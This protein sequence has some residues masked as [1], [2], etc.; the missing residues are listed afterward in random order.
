MIN[1]FTLML[2]QITHSMN[3]KFI[4][5]YYLL[6]FSFLTSF[7][8]ENLIVKDTSKYNQE[9][10]PSEFDNELFSKMLFDKINEHR[11]KFEFDSI[12]DEE[13]LTQAAQD[14]GKYMASNNKEIIEQSGKKKT[15]GDRIMFYGGSKF[16]YELT[17]KVTIKKGKIYLT[18][19]QAIDEIIFKWTNSKK[20][21][22]ILDDKNLIFVGI[23]AYVD[24]TEKRLYVSA[25]FGNYKSFNKGA[26][27]RKELAVPYTKRKYGLKHFDFTVCKKCNKYK[28]IGELQ[29]N[30][31]VRDG[32]IWFKTDNVKKFK[33][34][35]KGGKDGI[36]VDIVQRAQYSCDD[37]NIIDN[38]L[39]NKGI[40]L[41]R[42][43]KNKLFRKNVYK[44]PKIRRQKLEVAIGKWPKKLTGNKNEYELNLVIIKEKHVCYNI[45]QS[46]TDN[47][48][49]EFNQSGGL[50]A[51][52]V[53]VEGFDE[54]IPKPEIT[55]LNF[56][57]PFEKN[58]STYKQEDI[59]PFVDALNEPEFIIKDLKVNAYS[60]IEGNVAANI[61][62]QKR[63]AESIIS[64]LKEMQSNKDIKAEIT[65]D[66]SWEDFKRDVVS[67]DYPE[68]AEKTKE[69]AQKY[70]KENKLSDKL[71]PILKNERYAEMS[72]TVTYDIKGKKQQ[73][74]V[75]S[76]FNRAAK[77]CD[78]DKALLIQKYIFKQVLNE[79]YT[80]DAIFN[81]VIDSTKAD[82]AGLLMNKLW[83]EQWASDDEL[84][85]NICKRIDALNK[86]APKNNYILYNKY[87][88]NI[89]AWN[90]DNA[91]DIF[92][93]QKKINELYKSPLSK[94]TV[95]NLNLEFQ[96]KIIGKYDTLDKPIDIVVRSLERIK[97][98]VNVDGS[99]WKDALK[100]SY[101]F[102]EHKDYDFGAKLLEPFVYNKFVFDE[103]IFTYISLC[104][105]S[106]YRMMSNRFYTAML[107]AKELDKTRFC[108]LFAGDKL[109][110]QVLENTQVKKLYCKNCDK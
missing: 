13:I 25:V 63:R 83:L 45:P 34:L 20:K 15:T 14:N 11:I 105:H 37:D 52:T 26:D 6:F 8:Q 23:G 108:K 19:R 88:C 67:T 94:E 71:E 28:N 50:I 91:S 2:N 80:K 21:L 53:M 44:E 57:I 9:I 55:E 18:Y 12:V 69:E 49:L 41:K 93:F 40:L 104:S 33:K 96:F 59:K 7:A 89:N 39:V 3:S 76:R 101:L 75:V 17:R 110:I 42:Y 109:S 99:S 36:A 95:D 35:I 82:C 60:S 79:N 62:L 22:E 38:N 48:S 92:M 1:M 100:L 78:K 47:G 68:L 103:L 46:Y 73:P 90:S 61:K 32:K 66:D 29:A 81:Q 85:N 74:Y 24:G 16:G 84:N 102:M 30:L 27:K 107:K 10:D 98:I 5:F 58:K 43:Y 72:M 70:I 51:D 4:L 97:E 106:N 65:T 77:T 31:F 87:I 56:R 54:Y 86:L 64:T